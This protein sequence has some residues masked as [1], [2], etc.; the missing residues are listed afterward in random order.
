VGGSIR[1]V[2]KNGVKLVKKKPKSG[3]VFP[4]E[5]RMGPFPRQSRDSQA[6]ST[7]EDHWHQRR[8]RINARKGRKVEKNVPKSENRFFI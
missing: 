8:Y 4:K 2:E 5:A 1:Q 7:L 3:I 6:G